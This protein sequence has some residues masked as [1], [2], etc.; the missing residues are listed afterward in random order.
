[1]KLKRLLIL[2]SAVVCF[3]ACDDYAE[4]EF[5]SFVAY[6]INEDIPI[7]ETQNSQAVLLEEYSG[8]KCTNCP[9]AAKELE[10]LKESYKEKLVAVTIHAG[11]FAEPTKRNDSLDLTTSYGNTLQEKF[12]VAAF[13]AGIINRS[14]SAMLY[15][16]WESTI[17]EKLNTMSH[18]L[19][20]GLGIKENSQ[21]ILVG[22]ELS[23]LKNITDNLLLT[24]VVVEDGIVGVQLDGAKEITDYVFYNV[25]R[26]N[27]LIDLPV[28]TESIAS[29]ETLKWNYGINIDPIWNLSNCR[30]VA[31]VTNQQTGQVI[32]TNEISVR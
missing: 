1:M 26:E 11:S 24:L 4:E 15:S 20:I 31:I 7:T 17:T 14:T 10:D 5:V 18:S 9:K 29:G 3:V 30:V 16:D 13:P 27:A 19:N 21:R 32:Q 28:N 12:G 23:A 8:W 2:L 6:Q 25:L 22:V